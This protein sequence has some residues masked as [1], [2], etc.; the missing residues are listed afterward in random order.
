MSRV[1]CVGCGMMGGNIVDALLDAGHEVTIVDV[2]DRGA[3]SRVERGAR[4]ETRLSEALDARLIVFSVPNDDVVRSVLASCPVGSLAGSTI[5]NTTSEVPSDVLD[6]ERIVHEAGAR[7][8]DATIL[9]YQ[10][11]VGSDRACLLY[12]GDGEAFEDL[13]HELTAL[14]PEPLYLGETTVAAEIVDLV[15][16]AAHYGLCYA[17]LE[18]LAW[19]AAAGLDVDEYLA[20]LGELLDAL[21]RGLPMTAGLDEAPLAGA[22]GAMRACV[23]ALERTDVAQRLG[24]RRLGATNRSVAHHYRKLLSILSSGFSY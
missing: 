6:V 24:P 7:Y 12:A 9:T 4:F 8:L 23:R 10:G 2:D 11:E 22:S 20:L 13:R 21:A 16:V 17:P 15:V 1:T 5:V 3:R 14:S 19:C 18:G